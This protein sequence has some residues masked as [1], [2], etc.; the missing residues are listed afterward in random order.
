MNMKRSKA[1]SLPASTGVEQKEGRGGTE[2]AWPEGLTDQEG[3][4]QDRAARKWQWSARS[5]WGLSCGEGSKA[6]LV[7]A[8]CESTIRGGPCP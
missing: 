6:L 7:A 1:S 2:V 3:S 8:V 5:D 4:W